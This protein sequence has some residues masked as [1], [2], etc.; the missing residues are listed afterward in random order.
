MKN[1]VCV[2]H[3]YYLMSAPRYLASLQFV[4]FYSILRNL[5]SNQIQNLHFQKTIYYIDRVLL[6]GSR[7]ITGN[8][9]STPHDIVLPFHTVNFT[10]HWVLKS[11][12]FLV[13]KHRFIWSSN[14]YIFS[15]NIIQVLLHE[16]MVRDWGQLQW[17]CRAEASFEV[18][19][20]VDVPLDYVLIEKIESKVMI[21]N[22]T[23]M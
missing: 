13:Q 18:I 19:L 2:T 3:A 12:I 9:I 7:A 15:R 17:Q 22:L 11:I 8:W 10:N 21:W 5:Q 6:V 20:Y 16:Q 14:S 4:E 23:F 1:L